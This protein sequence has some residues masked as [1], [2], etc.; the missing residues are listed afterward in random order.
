MSMATLAGSASTI[1]FACSTMPML[2][3]AFRTKDLSSYSLGNILLSNV[4][5]LIYSVYVFSLP[6]GPIWL[7]HSFYLITTGLML[8]WY[9]R[10]EADG[11][12][13]APVQQALDRIARRTGR[14]YRLPSHRQLAQHPAGQTLTGNSQ[15]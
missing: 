12:D 4:G 6:A 2:I 1:I 14:K 15:G 10:Y 13:W 3:K 8:I 11:G 9:L 7:L 5:N